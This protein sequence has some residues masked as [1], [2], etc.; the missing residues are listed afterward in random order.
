MTWSRIPQAVHCVPY[1]HSNAPPTRNAPSP[2]S[3]QRSES[4][5][6]EH[7]LEHA[8]KPA[9]GGDGGGLGGDGGGFGM[10][11][12]VPAAYER[13]PR[14]VRVRCGQSVRSVAKPHTDTVLPSVSVKKTDPG[15]PSLHTPSFACEHELSPILECNA[16]YVRGPQY[17]FCAHGKGT[18]EWLVHCGHATTSG[19]CNSRGAP[20]GL[21]E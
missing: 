12:R 20:R 8:V 15:P 18:H 5:D 21:H 13:G 11:W 14:V 6:V 16:A 4:V 10:S 17:V 3:E 9:G 19:I 1:E 2:P 7:V